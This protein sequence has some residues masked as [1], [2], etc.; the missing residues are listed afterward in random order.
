MSASVVILTASVDKG[1]KNMGAGGTSTFKT[2]CW[3][4]NYNVAKV[5]EKLPPKGL[6]FAKSGGEGHGLDYKTIFFSS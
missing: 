1:S 3:R 6:K 5:C 2:E 4:A